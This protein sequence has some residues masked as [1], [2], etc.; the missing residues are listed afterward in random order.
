MT[1]PCPM[2]LDC[3]IYASECGYPGWTELQCVTWQE[4]NE[5]CEKEESERLKEEIKRLQSILGGKFEEAIV[6][7]P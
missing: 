6:P 4:C 3:L 2:G 7:P 1:E 5:C